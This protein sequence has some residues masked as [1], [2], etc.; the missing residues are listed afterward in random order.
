MGSASHG[1]ETVLV[2]VAI[3]ASHA[4]VVCVVLVV[5][6]SMILRLCVTD[7]TDPVVRGIAVRIGVRAADAE[8]FRRLHTG[9]RRLDLGSYELAINDRRRIARCSLAEIDD[10]LDGETIY[11]IGNDLV[12]RVI[13]TEIRNEGHPDELVGRPPRCVHLDRGPLGDFIDYDARSIP[14]GEITVGA[15]D[16]ELLLTMRRVAICALDRPVAVPIVGG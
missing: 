4:E 1:L 12:A 13:D 14:G 7:L 10:A 3:C 2:E 15:I 6:V 16:L 11:C 5:A 8:E 9:V